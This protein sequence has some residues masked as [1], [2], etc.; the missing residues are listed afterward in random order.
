MVSVKIARIMKE[1]QEVIVT[2]K[3]LVPFFYLSITAC[4]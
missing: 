2:D 4:H 3:L 1:E